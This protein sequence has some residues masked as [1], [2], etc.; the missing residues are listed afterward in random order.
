MVE[1]EFLL[2]LSENEFNPNDKYNDDPIPE[3]DTVSLSSSE[4]NVRNVSFFFHLIIPETIK[5][6]IL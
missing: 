6:L 2:S 4:T 5:K 3:L 1:D